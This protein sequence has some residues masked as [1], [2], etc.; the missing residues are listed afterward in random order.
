MLSWWEALLL[1]IF[2]L[3]LLWL[4]VK[5]L[6]NIGPIFSE[7]GLLLALLTSVYYGAAMYYNTPST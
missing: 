3:A 6:L 5:I 1:N 2:M 7:Y 4:A